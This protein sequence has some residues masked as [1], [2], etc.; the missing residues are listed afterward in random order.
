MFPTCINLYVYDAKSNI[1]VLKCFSANKLFFLVWD[2]IKVF[3]C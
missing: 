1:K 2:F 3:Q